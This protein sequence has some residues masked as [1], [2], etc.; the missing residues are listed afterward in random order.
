MKPQLIRAK[1]RSQQ[2]ASILFAL[3]FFIV[4]AV[5]GSIVLT[6]ATAAAGRLAGVK[7][8][9][10]RYY[11]V[12]SAADVLTHELGQM[13]AQ[14]QI[15]VRAE[16]STDESVTETNAGVSGGDA[17]GGDVS[18][19]VELSALTFE[20]KVPLADLL[21]KTR[22]SNLD[23]TIRHNG[24]GRLEDDPLNARIATIF[25][26]ESVDSEVGTNPYNCK[27]QFC[28]T[29]GQYSLIL[30]CP[31]HIDRRQS[32]SESTSVTVAADG[33]RVETK[34]TTTTTKYTITWS[35]A[36]VV[37]GGTVASA[38]GGGGTS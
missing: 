4:C 1:L 12:N 24:A 30:D 23:L 19:G 3:F 6:A 34:T 31:A 20:S 26:Y 33:S 38:A 10:Q 15:K 36:S 21:L 14:G 27:I 17:S 29:D 35:V 32:V 13:D 25:S 2:G 5:I 37:K 9:N 7:E 18:G 11:A 16:A 8:R 28:S 22:G